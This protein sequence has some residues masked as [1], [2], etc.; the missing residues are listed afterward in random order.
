LNIHLGYE[1]GTGNAIEIPLGHLCVTGQTQLSGKTTTLEALIDRSKL[2]AVSFVTKRGE[3][4]FEKSHRIPPFFKQRAD[5]QFVAGLLEAT[6]R[7]KMKFQRPWIM[8]VCKGATSLKDVLANVINAKATAR[9]LNE[10]IYTELEHYLEIVV[11]QLRNLP[12]AATTAPDL[13]LG[14]NV[15]DLTEYTTEVQS[16]IIQS[17]LGWVYECCLNTIVIIPEAWEFIPQDRGNPVKLAAETYIRKAAGLKNYLWV[18]SQD[19]AGVDKTILK[20][21]SVW[22]MGVQREHNEVVRALKH[23]PF[24]SPKPKPEDIMSLEIG[25]FF[26][27]HGKKMVRTYVQ[28]SWMDNRAAREVAIGNLTIEDAPVRIQR[29]HKVK[30]ED[31]NM[32][33]KAAYEAE[34][35]RA[36]GLQREKETTTTVTIPPPTIKAYPVGGPEAAKTVIQVPNHPMGGAEVSLVEQVKAAILRDPAAKMIIASIIPELEVLTTRRVI[37]IDGDSLKGRLAQLIKAGYFDSGAKG[38]SAWQE[39]CRT[40]KDPGKANVYRALSDL[41]DEGFL[42]K[43][44]EEGFTAV[45]GMKVNVI[46]A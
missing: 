8:K 45:P 9:G 10:S 29:P 37:K 46:A 26:V 11:P 25:Q 5:W 42:T 16:L 24:G 12:Y 30:D 23:I 15:M 14:V 36:D 43:E 31:T 20:Q 6:L 33:Y 18:D 39:L 13:K 44:G 19:V 41:R 21:C 17:V 35:A 1:V 22:I 34:K 2:T 4:R 3:G 27:S 40:G 32:D 28:P 7:E 38:Y